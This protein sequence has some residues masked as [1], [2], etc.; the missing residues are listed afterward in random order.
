MLEAIGK[1]GTLSWTESLSYRLLLIPGTRR[2]L[3]RHQRGVRLDGPS[4]RRGAAA[5]SIRSTRSSTGSSARPI[6]ETIGNSDMTPLWGL[7]LRDGRALHW[8]GLN[9]SLNEV[10]ISSAIGNGA[11]AKSVDLES[12]DRVGDWLRDLKPP[13]YPF[14]ID[15]TLAD[16]GRRRLRHRVRVVSRTRWRANGPGHSDRRSRDRSP[17]PRHLDRGVGL[18][19]Q[20]SRRRQTVAVQVFRKTDGYVAMPLLGD[21]AQRAVS[22]QR[23]GADAHRLAEP[24][25]PPARASI[26]AT[27]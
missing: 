7:A 22:A 12:L 1:I 13:A 15:R 16:R 17:P 21:V 19:V 27:T 20:R 8:D 24:A 2:A 25:G 9:S 18:G 3:Q 4:A 23:L 26:A 10:L 11:S 6:D 14:P 5:G